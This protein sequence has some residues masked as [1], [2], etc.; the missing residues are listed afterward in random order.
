MSTDLT[1]KGVLITGGSRGIGAATARRLAARGASIYLAGKDTGERFESVVAACR[2]LAP[3]AAAT[4][5][6]G[7]HDLAVPGV[8]EAMVDAA[9]AALGRI[10]ALVNNAAIRIRQR[11]GEFSAAEFDEMVAVNLRGPFLASQAV[12]PHMRRQGGGRIVNVASQMAQIA[13]QGS[14]LYGLTKAAL[15]HLTKSMAFELGAHNIQVNAVSPGPTMT[16]Y[17]QARTVAD[18]ALLE[19]KLSYIPAGRYADPEEIAEVIE[20]LLTTHA[21]I[22]QGHDLVVDGGYTIH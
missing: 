18:P 5:A 8:A 20:F 14:T 11:F 12:I 21:T 2:D 22:L 16:E 13:E 1:G 4:F 3:D 7:H 17:N 15:V 6:F 19:H 9:A 10:D